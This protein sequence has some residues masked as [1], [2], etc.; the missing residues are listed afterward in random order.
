MGIGDQT[1]IR[2]NAGDVEAAASPFRSALIELCD[3]R[4]FSRLTVAELCRRAG[5][6]PAAFRRRY[7]DLEDCFFDVCRA[8]LRRYARH[9]ALARAGLADWRSRLRATT[10]ALYRFAAEDERRGRFALVESRAAGE[11]PALLIATEL[12]AIYELI[13]EGRAEPT[14]PP[15]LTRATA[16][17]LGGGIFTRIYHAAAGPGPLPP[18]E[19]FVPAMMYGAVLPYLGAVAAAQELHLPAPKAGASGGG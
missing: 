13:D 4:G 15:S 10:Y 17:C 12:E 16:E 8:E 18:E 11:R 3:E 5:S 19:E 1:A 6:S 9:A 2:L 7:S 14:A